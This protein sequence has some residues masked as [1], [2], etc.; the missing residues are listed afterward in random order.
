MAK[1]PAPTT[2]PHQA[3]CKKPSGPVRPRPVLEAGYAKPPPSKPHDDRRAGGRLEPR[4]TPGTARSYA[5]LAPAT[6]PLLSPA[7]PRFSGDRP[8]DVSEDYLL[9]LGL[10]TAPATA[11]RWRSE[12][13][14]EDAAH[15]ELWLAFNGRTSERFTELLGVTRSGKPRGLRLA[16][17]GVA[18]VAR[19]DG[20]IGWERR[21]CKDRHCP[22]CGMKRARQ[23]AAAI[24]AW[25]F[26]NQCVEA[27][28][29]PTLTQPKIANEHPKF[30][31]DRLLDS[32]RRFTRSAWF[33]HNVVGGVRSVEATA[34]AA[35]DMVGDY[36]VRIPGIHAHIHAIVEW[37]RPP[38][39]LPP[40]D[41]S[42]DDI[43]MCRVAALLHYAN[44]RGQFAEQWVQYTH[45]DTRA[46]LVK[47]LD[48]ENIYQ[49][50]NYCCNLSGLLEL[51]DIAPRYVEQVIEAL[52]SRHLVFSFGS[53]RGK[54]D[55]SEPGTLRFGDRAVA[56][57]ASRPPE[58]QRPVQ[59]CGG[60]EDTA[61]TVLA[62]V[63]ES[64]KPLREPRPKS[65]NERQDVKDKAAQRAARRAAAA[66]QSRALT[67]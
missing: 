34:R 25:V 32:W 59:W 3:P 54:L 64:P 11:A 5:V 56:T 42:P 12:G 26:K 1:P 67:A 40:S 39:T 2:T 23:L 22:H 17:C 31:L 4:E 53:W 48:D 19:A 28:A 27:C 8:R 63:L 36:E 10:E 16:L 45:G 30:A 50:T 51:V 55:D 14:E 60:G 15:L 61:A 38:H 24:R 21:G 65:D 18:F 7:T 46:C 33:R 37:R 52:A 44:L 57:L 49:V 58:T 43:E 66:A 9:Q 47:Q 41:A 62:A 6:D 35:G 13:Y 20:K 29:F